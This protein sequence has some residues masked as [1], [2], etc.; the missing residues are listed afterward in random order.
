MIAEVKKK[1]GEVR[2]GW[3]KAHI[4]ILGTRPPMCWQK[5]LRRVPLDDHDKWMTGGGIRQWAKQRKRRYLETDGLG[6]DGSAVIGRAMKLRRKA[7]TNY[8]RPR[9]IPK[10]W[11]CVID[12]KKT[13]KKLL[14]T[15]RRKGHR[16][17]VGWEDRTG[18]GCGVPKVWRRG[19]NAGAH[20]IPVWKYQEG[21]GWKGKERVGEG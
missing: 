3:A 4:G 19:G 1:G 21:E 5:M 9:I 11:E 20:C 18:G 14:S 2:I 13:K 12:V 7:V 15:V 17:V 8:C 6:G 10:T 16:E